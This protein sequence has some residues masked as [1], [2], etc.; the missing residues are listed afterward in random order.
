MKQT[1]YY[2]H[3]MQDL[4]SYEIHIALG[5]WRVLSVIASNRRRVL[6]THRFSAVLQVA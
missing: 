1:L 3:K 4:A 5:L 6:E 2:Y